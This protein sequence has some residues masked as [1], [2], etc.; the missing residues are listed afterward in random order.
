MGSEM[1]I[2]DRFDN[3]EALRGLVTLQALF[4]VIGNCTLALAAWQLQR[5]RVVDGVSAP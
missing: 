5:R 1:C 3:S 4:T 2:R